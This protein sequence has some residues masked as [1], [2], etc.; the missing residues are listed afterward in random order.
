[1]G[2]QNFADQEKNELKKLEEGETEGKK[3]VTFLHG[4]NEGRKCCGTIGG[5]RLTDSGQRKPILMLWMTKKKG[6][7]NPL[8]K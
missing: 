4:G 3:F 1:M 7:R 2:R 5:G 8:K 6:G